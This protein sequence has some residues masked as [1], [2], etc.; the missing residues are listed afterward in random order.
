MHCLRGDTGRVV[1]ASFVFQ[2]I[3]AKT[4]QQTCTF[5][6]DIVATVLLK[7]IV[8]KR[9]VCGLWWRWKG[10]KGEEGGREGGTVRAT[11][12]RRDADGCVRRTAKNWAASNGEADHGRVGGYH[13]SCAF[14]TTGARAS[15]AD[16]ECD[17]D[18]VS[19]GDRDCPADHALEEQIV[20]DPGPQPREE[21]MELVIFARQSQEEIVGVVVRDKKITY[22]MFSVLNQLAYC[23][24]R[25]WP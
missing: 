14:D 12:E 15:H 23:M 18:V 9:G 13:G 25:V 3:L 20:D 7:G 10:Q 6:S 21:V 4:Q 16:R 22:I 8:F 2:P 1:A 17:S 24:T 19:G 5:P 11:V